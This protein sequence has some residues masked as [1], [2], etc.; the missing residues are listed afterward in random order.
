M[1]TISSSVVRFPAVD[2]NSVSCTSQKHIIMLLIDT[3]AQ[4]VRS[5]F[6]LRTFSSY[7]YRNAT[8]LS[9]LCWPRG[10]RRISASCPLVQFCSGV[11]RKGTITPSR[12][13]NSPLTSDSML[14]RGR[15]GRRST[16]QPPTRDKRKN[17]NQLNQRPDA[18][19]PWPGWETRP[20]SAPP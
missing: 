13:I 9:S 7:T 11:R 5:R 18:P 17:H 4:P 1:W 15:R 10:N 20:L 19:S 12:S 8:T 14:S 16:R 6:P 2:R 3:A